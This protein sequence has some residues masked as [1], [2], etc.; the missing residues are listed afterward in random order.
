MIF[1]FVKKEILILF[2]N[3]KTAGIDFIKTL[4]SH[5]ILVKKFK[6]TSYTNKNLQKA[7]LS[8]YLPFFEGMCM[9][10]QPP[11]ILLLVVYH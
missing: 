11:N 7:V 1:E 9:H 10:I 3:T 8:R 4:A 6:S 5:R 2:A